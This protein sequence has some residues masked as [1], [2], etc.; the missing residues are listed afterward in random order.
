MPL[1]ELLIWVD[2][3]I[4]R[5]PKKHENGKQNGSVWKG[6]R[7]RAFEVNDLARQAAEATDK[8][9]GEIAGIQV[10]AESASSANRSTK[11]AREASAAL[12]A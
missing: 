12:A 4:P 5:K 9:G 3:G 8:I 6:A 7:G 10:I 1:A 2:E 11:E